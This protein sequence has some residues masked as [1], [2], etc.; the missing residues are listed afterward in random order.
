MMLWLKL[1]LLICKATGNSDN[2]V[3]SMVVMVLFN[4]FIFISATKMNSENC[5]QEVE[6][7]DKLEMALNWHVI[8]FIFGREIKEKLKETV[9][10]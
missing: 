3:S 4:L 5:R 9:P 10:W 8:I 2:G 1:V 7:V 6:H